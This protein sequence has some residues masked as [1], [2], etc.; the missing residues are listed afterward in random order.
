MKYEFFRQNLPNIDLLNNK[1]LEEFR[2]YYVAITRGRYQY[3]NARG[4]QSQR[5]ILLSQWVVYEEISNDTME[6][7]TI[8]ICSI[9]ANTS[10]HHF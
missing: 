5:N 4:Y 2:L 6:N 9:Y 8:H 1:Q 7:I 10:M 3:E